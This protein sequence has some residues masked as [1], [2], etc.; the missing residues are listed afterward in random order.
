MFPLTSVSR[1]ISFIKHIIGYCIKK[2]NIRSFICQNNK[3]I[4]ALSVHLTN[5]NAANFK[6][7][8]IISYYNFTK[9]SDFK[10]ILF[11][12]MTNHYHY[13][14]HCKKLLFKIT[15]NREDSKT[16][17]NDVII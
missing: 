10:Y 9:C 15:S 5:G 3:E 13:T 12:K 4:N 14:L 7:Y 1:I 6:L 11:L 16:L 17:Q 2:T 8:F